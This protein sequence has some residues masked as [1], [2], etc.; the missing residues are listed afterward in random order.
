MWHSVLRL[1]LILLGLALAPPAATVEFDP[2][3]EALV[4]PV[5][6]GLDFFDLTLLRRQLLP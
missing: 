4:P 2:L 1:G 6:S 3:A 5:A